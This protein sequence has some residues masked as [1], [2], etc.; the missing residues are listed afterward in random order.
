MKADYIIGEMRKFLKALHHKR[1]D[2]VPEE[3]VSH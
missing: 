2:L 1:S 3:W